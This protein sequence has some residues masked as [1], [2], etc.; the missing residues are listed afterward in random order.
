MNYNE[1]LED[2]C[3]HLE[4]R[5]VRAYR[6]FDQ[7]SV[8]IRGAEGYNVGINGKYMPSVI[9]D[10]IYLVPIEGPALSLCQFTKAVHMQISKNVIESMMERVPDGWNADIHLTPPC[11]DE[12]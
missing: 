9:N 2:I 6:P 5:G 12:G 4:S 10:Q 3:Q 7:P 8:S 11:C 1:I